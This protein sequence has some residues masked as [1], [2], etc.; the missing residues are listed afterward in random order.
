MLRFPI[1][2]GLSNLVRYHLGSVAFG[3]FIIALIKFIRLIIKYLERKLKQQ[4]GLGPIKHIALFL[5]RCCSCCLACFERCMKYL[6]K[7]AYI[8]VGE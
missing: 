1:I 7:N 2:T 3:S 8:E 4:E 6:N 5:L